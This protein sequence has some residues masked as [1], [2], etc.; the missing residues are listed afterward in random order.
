M[1]IRELKIHLNEIKILLRVELM[2]G[3]GDKLGELCFVLEMLRRALISNEFWFVEDEN[4]YRRL[5]KFVVENQDV[6]LKEVYK[7]RESRR[8][9]IVSILEDGADE[10]AQ[11]EKFWP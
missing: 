8:D 1:S 5:S 6:N 3:T 10:E 7:D 11:E 2:Y 9:L 4:V